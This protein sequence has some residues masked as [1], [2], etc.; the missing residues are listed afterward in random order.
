MKDSDFYYDKLN[1]CNTLQC[2][3][4]IMINS[5]CEYNFIENKNP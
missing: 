3:T 2:I 1:K 4:N 5:T